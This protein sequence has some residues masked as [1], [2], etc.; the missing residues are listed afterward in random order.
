MRSLWAYAVPRGR[1]KSVRLLQCADII[2]LPHSRPPIVDQ[3]LLLCIP[4]GQTFSPDGMG[5]CHF[6]V[7]QPHC[8]LFGVVVLIGNINMSDGKDNT[9][10]DG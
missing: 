5:L 10:Q 3:V 4:K 8:I 7:A 2:R 6:F 1:D 9:E